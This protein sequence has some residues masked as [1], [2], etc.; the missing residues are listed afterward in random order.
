MITRSTRKILVSSVS[1]VDAVASPTRRQQR[2]SRT[3]AGSLCLWLFGLIVLG[4]AHAAQLTLAWDWT[5][6]SG[7]SAYFKVERKTGTTGTYAQVGTTGTGIKQYVDT[8]NNDTTYCYRVRASDASGDSPY[9]G[10][11]CG[12]VP[13][14]SSGVSGSSGEIIVDNAPAGVQDGS[15]SYVGSWCTS[16]APNFYGSDS[17]YSCGGTGDRYRWT[18]SIPAT[19]TYDVYVRWTSNTS[20][21]TSV[22]IS[23][24]HA[25]GTTV[26]SFNEQADGGTWI[27]HGQ[28]RL[29]A[30]TSGYVEASGEN[31]R[32][33][34]D[35]IRLVPTT[36]SSA[37]APTPSPAPSPSPSPTPSPSPIGGSAI[38]VALQSNGGV[39]SASTAIG[40]YPA[41]AVTDGDR[42]GLSW[43]SGGGGWNDATADSFPDWVQ[44]NFNGQKTISRIDVVTVQDNYSAPIDP[45]ASTT[46]TAYG[47]TDFEV[48]YW[49]G[50]SWTPVPGATVTGNNLV[51]RSFSFSPITTDRIRVV[52]IRALG[53]YSRVT[54]VEAWTSGGSG[55]GST[56]ATGV[57]AASAA[58]GASVSASSEYGG[59]PASAVI[60]GDRKGV[61]WGLGAGGWNDATPDA[62]PDWVQINFN[63]TKSIGRVDVF[64]LQD[65]IAAPVNPT[66]T[67]TFS[68]YGVT[69]LQVQ[70]WTSSGWTPIPGAS[71]SGNN[72]VWRSFTFAPV[73]TDRIRVLVTGALASHSRITEIEAWTQ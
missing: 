67:M 29:N 65:N 73:S 43:G 51:W 9:S 13:S 21:S 8:V 71:A 23:V 59:Y 70:Y 26:R 40:G 11:A 66:P 4:E 20:R 34:A 42:K 53:S 5:D 7:R 14:T 10:E 36:S 60:D 12:S 52:V 44:V 35:A 1:D 61:N 57:N 17:L 27:L 50:S 37:P 54:E 24:T 45:T 41:S 56:A 15:R 69:A 38:N 18:P 48:Q 25:A 22:P 28:Y 19:G 46:F 62:F 58:N 32:A 16:S 31:G 63:G 30:G 72:L 2:N 47:I 68:S 39:A 3:T 6:S 33:S 64:T 49:N 55:S